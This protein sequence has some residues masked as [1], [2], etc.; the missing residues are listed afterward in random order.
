MTTLFFDALIALL[1]L[2]DRG[3]TAVEHVRRQ[4]SPPP[5]AD[6]QPAGADDHPPVSATGAG[7][8]PIRN[9]SE[10]LGAAAAQLILLYEDRAPAVV[11]ELQF[12]LID[13]AAQ[14]KAAG[15]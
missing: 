14:F 9:T 8:H 5:D 15:D 2:T 10:L 7:G 4:A 13:R 12:D 1:K 6:A 11:R 3:L